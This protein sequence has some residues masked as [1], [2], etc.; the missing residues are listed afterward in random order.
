[1]KNNECHD[2]LGVQGNVDTQNDNKTQ[3]SHHDCI[4]YCDETFFTDL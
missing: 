4:N 1:M 3:K 2:T